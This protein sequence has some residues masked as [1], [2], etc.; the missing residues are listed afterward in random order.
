MTERNKSKGTTEDSKE[1]VIRLA[2]REAL[3]C[4][5]KLKSTQNRHDLWIKMKTN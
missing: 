4:K 2:E 1:I 3:Y 5:V